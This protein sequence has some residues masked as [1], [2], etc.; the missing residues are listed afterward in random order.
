[1]LAATLPAMASEAAVEHANR[2][3]VAHLQTHEEVEMLQ[4]LGLRETYHQIC[5]PASSVSN[6]VGR[7]MM[8]QKQTRQALRA[9]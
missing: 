1:M 3:T 6:G 7:D 9:Y 4:M 5:N 2:A 8:Q